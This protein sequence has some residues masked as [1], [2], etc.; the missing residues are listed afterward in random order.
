MQDSRS[1][2]KRIGE[3][4]QSRTGGNVRELHVDVEADLR[5]V[6][7]TGRTS[8][9]YSKQLATHA[10]YDVMDGAELTN[11]IEVLPV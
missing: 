6:I 11:D 7:I 8:T 2:V 1:L 5:R 10:V 9:Y 4:V 3:A